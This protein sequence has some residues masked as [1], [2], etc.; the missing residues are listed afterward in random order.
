MA[1]DFD[2]LIVGGGV[3]GAAL[4]LALAQHEVR[5]LVIERRAGPGN[6]NRGDSL[7][8][9]V[10]RHLK[11]WGALDRFIAAGA[12][13]V[14]KMQVFHHKGGLLL[15]APLVGPDGSPYLV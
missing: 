12:N 6:I 14:N 1:A 7:L 3:G 11:K 9:A 15:E 13:P 2:V 4:A 5:V 10:T 8:P